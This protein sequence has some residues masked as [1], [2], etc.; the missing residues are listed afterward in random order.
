MY[1]SK[2]VIAIYIV[3]VLLLGGVGLWA[4]GAFDGLTSALNLDILN[5]QEEMAEEQEQPQ[6]PQNELMTGSNAS[7]QALEQDVNQ[8]DAELEAF[9]ESSAELDSSLEDESIEQEY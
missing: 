7:D 4:A 9:N 2:L 8:L 5:P 1:I 6:E 3:L